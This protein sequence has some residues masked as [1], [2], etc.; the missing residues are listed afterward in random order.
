MLVRADPR[1]RTISAMS[2][3]RDLKAEIPGHG[4]DKINAAYE[5]GGPR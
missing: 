5:I 4:S 3:P 1:T 2:I